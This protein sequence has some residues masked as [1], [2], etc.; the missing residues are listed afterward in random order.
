VEV[1]GQYNNKERGI[2]LIEALVSTAIVAIGFIAIFQMVSYSV[3]AIDVSNERTKTSYMT[4]MVAEDILADKFSDISG[5]K[6]YEYMNDTANSSGTNKEYWKQ[7]TCS[8]G[9]SA[10]SAV[11]NVLDEKVNKWDKRFSTR[12][13]K[14]DSKNVG[15]KTLKIFEICDGC[16]YHNDE[17]F[18]KIYFGKMQVTI[19]STGTNSLGKPRQKRKF[20]YFQIH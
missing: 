8:D 11:S 6:L 4:S 14:C 9:S 3:Q 20:L 12:R 1:V 17:I 7:L 19:K 2:T 18:E 10:S 5:K 16:T 13:L 15:Q